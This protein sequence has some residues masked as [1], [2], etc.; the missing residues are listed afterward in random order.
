[1]C[2]VNTSTKSNYAQQSQTR[3]K[4]RFLRFWQNLVKRLEGRFLGHV[5]D[6]TGE[7]NVA[8]VSQLPYAL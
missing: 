1:M 4:V 7:I 5:V 2:P 8:D 3:T 6:S